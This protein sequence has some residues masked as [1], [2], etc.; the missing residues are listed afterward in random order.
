MSPLS[1]YRRIPAGNPISRGDVFSR[2]GMFYRKEDSMTAR[3]NM[4]VLALGGL[5]FAGAP[6][7]PAHAQSGDALADAELTC[8]DYG[9]RPYSP[10]YNSCVDRVALSYDRGEPGLAVAQARAMGKARA[11]CGS[12][13][14]NPR[15][16]GYQQCISSE[17]D[18]SGAVTYPVPAVP[19]VVATIDGYGN[20]YDRYGNRLDIDGYVIRYAP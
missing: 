14:L 9:M 3:Q 17:I 15:T 10:A 12:Y 2:E 16:L 11:I 20:R 6:A 8:L 13:G 4:L 1:Q 19:R 18:K 7:I 5:V